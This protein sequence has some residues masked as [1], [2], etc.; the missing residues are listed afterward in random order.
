MK[1]LIFL[2][3]LIYT[4]SFSQWRETESLK[5]H[6]FLSGL[7]IYNG[8]IYGYFRSNFYISY[9]DGNNFEIIRT[10]LN[11]FEDFGE[12]NDFQIH[13]NVFYM[14]S[15]SNLEH[16]RF[17]NLYNSTDLGRTWNK[18]TDDEYSYEN[19]NIIDDVIY[20]Y[21]SNKDNRGFIF[22]SDNG[23]NWKKFESNEN[24][25][26]Y[27]FILKYENEIILAHSTAD[28]NRFEGKG[29][30]ISSDNGKTWVNKNQG[31]NG[32]GINGIIKIGE[33][34]IVATR[35][36]V[37][38]STNGEDLWRPSNSD[39]PP[40]ALWVLNIKE[41]GNNIFISTRGGLYVSKDTANSW[42]IVNPKLE[43]L[44][45]GFFN[46][47]EDTYFYS[48]SDSY[49][50]SI[51]S[52]DNFETFDTLNFKKTTFYLNF[53]NDNNY[54]FIA[55][56]YGV[57][58]QNIIENTFEL[59]SDFFKGLSDYVRHFQKKE[60]IMVAQIGSNLEHIQL[61]ETIISK[62]YGKT[63][64][65]VDFN[66][67]N[68]VKIL[69]YYINEENTIFTLTSNY[70]ILYTSDLGLTWN[71]LLLPENVKSRI[72]D[73]QNGGMYLENDS[74][75]VY[76]R[77]SIIKT[78]TKFSIFEEIVDHQDIV[79][80]NQMSYR[81]VFQMTKYKN[82]IS[83]FLTPGN[84][85]LFSYDYGKSWIESNKSFG[86]SRNNN[87]IND[88]IQIENNIFV[89]SMFGIYLSKDLGESWVTIEENISN[90][91]LFW[92]KNFFHNENKIYLVTNIAFYELDL[93]ELGINLKVE[94]K[95]ALHLYPPYPQP[96]SISVRI[97]ILWDNSLPF[98][99]EDIEIYN[100]SGEKIDIKG[101]ILIEKESA[102]IGIINWD[103]SGV[104]PGIYL[105][106]TTHG[107][108]T[109]ITKVMVMR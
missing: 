41:V 89:A 101:K 90:S 78:D 80:N 64:Q 92:S 27:K 84:V 106:K 102:N 40:S 83:V 52:T 100:L 62:D 87:I 13:N 58:K 56:K 5:F 25:D 21:F 105:V 50:Y 70:G 55:T 104:E 60:N 39:I 76:C 71:D 24:F 54:N 67:P 94:R 79:Y 82:F 34:L 43:G 48:I 33:N 91:E 63:W 1:N 108:A 14:L 53:I 4:T 81:N 2:I 18:I 35:S 74:I 26:S 6:N 98:N 97:R 72:S 3:I 96:S 28:N 42:Q 75:F 65:I 103:N 22:S 51:K 11:N 8:N 88:M 9:D 73:L 61:N 86:Y 44:S 95:N 93:E 17:R 7:T 37:F 23:E 85:V 46:Y 30:L 77:G 36:G 57:F 29:I 59:T 19:L 99:I 12:I 45:G 107:T 38:K 68:K 49:S 16:N 15:G 109:R 31:L 20:L 69:G 10:N 66:K 47:S 32:N